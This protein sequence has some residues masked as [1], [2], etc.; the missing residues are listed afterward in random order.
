MMRGRLGGKRRPKV[1]EVVNN[2]RENFSG[3][4]PRDIAGRR[5][6]PRAM[7]VRPVAPV[8]AVK[9]EQIMRAM[10][11]RPPGSQP[12]MASESLNTLWGALLSERRYPAK[13]KS[14]MA[15]RIGVVAILYISMMMAEESMPPKNNR[16]RAN[17]EM[18]IKRDVPKNIRRR[19]VRIK[20]RIKF[21]LH[22][23]VFFQPS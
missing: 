22:A 23:H 20:K 21:L 4:L 9:M 17:P 14:G 15:T 19:S 2:P 11:D 1:P 13:A 7:M 8:S 16:R 12:R 5:I 3:Y 18:T 6:P 10:M